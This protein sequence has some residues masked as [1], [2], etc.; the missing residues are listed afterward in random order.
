MYPGTLGSLHPPTQGP[1]TGS[2]VSPSQEGASLGMGGKKA[3]PTI[4]PKQEHFCSTS[5]PAAKVRLAPCEDESTVHS[6]ESGWSSVGAPC[7][8]ALAKVHGGRAAR[9]SVF[10]EGPG[11]QAQTL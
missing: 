7:P 6:D 3:D 10:Q 5:P 11:G 8:P 9:W 1:T 2:C 4:C